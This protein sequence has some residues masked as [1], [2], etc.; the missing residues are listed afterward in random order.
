[1]ICGSSFTSL[2][3]PGIKDY[4]SIRDA[5]D[6]CQVKKHVAGGSLM[7]LTWWF[8]PLTK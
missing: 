8:F 7:V 5:V 2:P 6:K 1:M 3:A 4:Q